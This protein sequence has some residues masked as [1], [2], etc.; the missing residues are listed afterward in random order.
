MIL[1]LNNSTIK[2]NINKTSLMYP[3]LISIKLN[4]IYDNENSSW[5]P[6]RIYVDLKIEF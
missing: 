1:S 4:P 6:R 5:L 2:N 3:S